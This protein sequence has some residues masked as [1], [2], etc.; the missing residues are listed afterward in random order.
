MSFYTQDELSQL[1]FQSIGNNV[2]LSKKASIYGHGRISIGDYSRIDDFVVL[3]AGDGGI[4]IGCNVHVAV[5]SSLIGA[6]KI[7]LSD[8]SNISSRVSIYSSN[9]DYSGEA[10]T[11]PTIPSCYTNVTHQGV[12]V[13]RHVVIGCGCVVLPGVQINEGTAIG[14][15]SLVKTDCKEWS[16]YAGNPVKIIRERK[17]DLLILEAKYKEQCQGA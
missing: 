4:N 10:M 14:A 9:D 7:T 6:G 11:N 8:F 15:L 17:K 13:G 16:V 12:C 3:S 2:L 1:G 5:F